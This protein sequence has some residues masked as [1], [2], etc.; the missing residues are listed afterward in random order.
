MKNRAKRI[1][2]LCLTAILAL[3]P[4]D[5]SFAA[6]AAAE[7]NPFEE[8]AFHIEGETHLE[9]LETAFPEPL[10]PLEPEPPVED[11]SPT[12]TPSPVLEESAAPVENPVETGD[13]S[14]EW[15]ALTPEVPAEPLS[16]VEK[17]TYPDA[18]IPEPVE[19]ATLLASVDASYVIQDGP[20]TL[21]TSGTYMVLSGEGSEGATT[22]T[23]S[24]TGPGEYTLIL[25]NVEINCSDLRGEAAVSLGGGANVT[26]TLA[27]TNT[28][29]SGENRA[30]IEV[31]ED[32]SL[33]INGNGSLTVSG[34]AGQYNASAGI[35]G[36]AEHTNGAISIQSGTITATGGARSYNG[37]AGIGGGCKGDGQRITISGGTVTANGSPESYYGAAGIGGGAWGGGMDISITGGTVTATGSHDSFLG[38]AG[39]GGGY[40]GS[41]QR[42]SMSGGTV[43]AKSSYGASGNGAGIGGGYG[44]TAS[45][46]EISGNAK[47]TANANFVNGKFDGSN[48]AGI[49]GGGAIAEDGEKQGGDADHITISGGTVN[50][51]GNSRGAGIGGGCNGNA[52]DIQITGGQINAYGGHTPAS[53]SYIGG[54]GI[55]GGAYGSAER[56]TI[57]TGVTDT[58][59]LS[60]YNGYGSA[61]IGGGCHGYAKDITI[62]NSNLYATGNRGSYTYGAGIGG[63]LYGAGLNILIEG[64]TVEAS[65]AAGAAIGSG[66][67]LGWNYRSHSP[68]NFDPA[69]FYT[70]R[71]AKTHGTFP[72]DLKFAATV[73]IGAGS[74]ITTSSGS[75]AAIGSGCSNVGVGY[76]AE[77]ITERYG[78]DVYVHDCEI[79]QAGTSSSGAG[80]G[81]G[82]DAWYCDSS[83][84]VEN[85]PS[86]TAQA[87]GSWQSGAS[88]GSG[89][90]NYWSNMELSVTDCGTLTL[91]GYYMHGGAGI[92]TGTSN[93]GGTANVTVDHC[94]SIHADVGYFG[95]GLGTGASNGSSSTSYGQDWRDTTEF[96]LTVT[97]CGPIEITNSYSSS[98]NART[99]IGSG[100]SNQYNHVEVSV[101]DC[102]SI[103]V[104]THS[105][106]MVGIG[107]GCGNWN[108]TVH[109]SLLRDGN[110]SL[111]RVGNSN[112]EGTGI[113]VG[114]GSG[115]SSERYPNDFVVSLKDCDSVAVSM[116]GQYAT[117]I[118][119]GYN[120]QSCHANITLD[121]C[122]PVTVIHSGQDSVGIGSGISCTWYNSNLWARS[123]ETAIQLKKCR[124]ISVAMAGINNTG[125]GC[126]SYSS[127]L[128]SHIALTDCGNVTVYMGQSPLNSSNSSTYRSTGIGMGRNV[129]NCDAN[130]Q[131]ARCGDV[132]VQYYD[133]NMGNAYETT[134]I[135]SGETCYSNS[136]QYTTAD[137]EQTCYPNTLHIQL[138]N[139]GAV[140]A[141]CGREGV[142]IGAGYSNRDTTVTVDITDCASVEA[143]GGYYA[144]GI[145]CG[146]SCYSN[147]SYIEG[148]RSSVNILRCPGGV[149]AQGGRYGAAIGSGGHLYHSGA[150]VEVRITD[151][152]SVVA[153]QKM[154]VD[155]STIQDVNASQRGHGAAIGG[156][157]YNT[158]GAKVSVH[159]TNCT[160]DAQSE[161][162]AAIGCGD[163]SNANTV[164]L[165]L[166]NC[167]VT[168][169]GGNGGGIGF[170]DTVTSG[171]VS[172]LLD[173][174]DTTATSL[175]YGAGIGGGFDNSRV[176]TNVTIDGGNVT[177]TGAGGGAG[178][179][180]GPKN[181]VCR[182]NVTIDGNAVVVATGS[183]ATDAHLAEEDDPTGS[184]AGA[185][186]GGTSGQYVGN[187][188]I[189]SGDVTAIG[190]GTDG[191]CAAGIGGGSNAKAG[192]IT[193]NGGTV[194]ATAGHCDQ[195][196][197][198]G[199]GGGANSNAGTVTIS[200]GNV[201]ATGRHGSKMGG[202]GIGGGPRGDGGTVVIEGGTVIAVGS[203]RGAGIGGGFN[204]NGGDVTISGGTVTVTGGLYD[205]AGIGGGA[206]GEGGTLTLSGDPT[207]RVYG[208]SSNLAIT[209]E[210]TTSI[211]VFQGTM[212]EVS[213]EEA[214][215]ALLTQ[216]EDGTKTG[217]TANLPAGYDAF[218]LNLP[219]EGMYHAY[220]QSDKQYLLATAQDAVEDFSLTASGPVSGEQLTVIRFFDVTFDTGEG[221]DV[222]A[223][224]VR[225]HKLVTLPE[226]PTRDGYLFAGWFVDE[227]YTSPYDFS[228]PVASDI[229]LYAKWLEITGQPYAVYH[230]KANLEGGWDIGA[231]E[232]GGEIP[233][234]LVTAKAMDY[235]GFYEDKTSPD[236]VAS[237]YTAEGTTLTLKLYYQ[238]TQVVVEVENAG[239]DYPAQLTAPYGTLMVL[240]KPAKEGY[241][242]DKWTDE[243]GSTIDASMP[244]KVENLGGVIYA[245]WVLQEGRAAYQVKHYLR[246]LE[247]AYVLR[248]AED[249]SGAVGDSVTVT[250]NTYSGFHVNHSISDETATGIIQADNSL[251][252]RVYYDRDLITVRLLETHNTA[253][254]ITVEYGAAAN[255][256]T[257]SWPG[258]TFHGWQRED[259][260]LY[261]D[262]DK[263][264]SLGEA[265]TAQWSAGATTPYTVRYYQ[266]DI[267][268]EDME[269]VSLEDLQGAAGSTVKASI[270]DYPGFT[271]NAKQSNI[272]G[273]VDA[274]H[275]LILNVYYTRNTYTVTFVSNGGSP[276]AAQ[277]GVYYTALADA[278]KPPSKTGYDFEGWYTDKGLGD[279]HSFAVPVTH[280][281]TLYAKW[282]PRED[283]RYI[284]RH[285]QQD[286]SGDDY[287]L[288]DTDTL[289]GITDAT[290]VA[291]VKSYSGF[292][293]AADHEGTL[294]S[295]EIAPDGST[296]LTLYYDRDLHTVTYNTLGGTS[297]PKA[298]GIRYG[299]A[300]PSPN[301]PVK[302][303]YTFQHWQKDN[304]GGERYDF[305]APVVADLALY[306]LWQPNTY[307]VSFDYRGATGN[308]STK[309][310]AV[311]YDAPYGELP[312]PTRHGY[313]FLGWFTQAQ[314]GSE[315]TA[316]TVVKITASQTL[317]A[318]WS[319]REDTPY[320]V[321][322]YQQNVS[323][324]GYTLADTDALT[325]VTDTLVTAQAK[326][327]HGFREDTSY[328]G[329]LSSGNLAGDG[330]LVLKLYY[331]R[332]RRTLTIDRANGQG[333]ETESVY[334]GA[335]R[336]MPQDPVR[337]G[338]TFAGWVVDGVEVQDGQFTMPDNHVALTATWEAIDY[339][340]TYRYVGTVPPG[341]PEVPQ[342]GS[343]YNIGEELAVE[344]VPT[345]DGY[346]LFG[347]TTQDVTVGGGK[348]RMPDGN[349]TFTGEW[350]KA[351]YNVIYVYQGNIPENAPT[352]P[353]D[354][355]AYQVGA[356]VAVQP[357][358]ELE[359]YTFS[360][361]RCDGVEVENGIFEMPIGNVVFRGSWT[362][363][364][365]RVEF[366]YTGDVPN[367]V[368][369]LPETEERTMDDVVTVPAVAAVEGY[370]FCGWTVDGKAIEDGAFPMPAKDMTVTG[371][372]EKLPYH[373]SY[374]YKGQVPKNAPA[375]PVD[376]AIYTVGDPVQPMSPPALRGYTFSGWGDPFSMP[377]HDVTLTGSWS[378]VNYCISY[379]LNG[380]S[381][382]QEAA[383]VYTI[384]TPTFPFPT[385][386]RSGYVFGGWYTDAA[387]A[388]ESK[389]DGIT[390]GSVGDITVY[391]KW[392]ASP[393]N[394]SGGGSSG[395]GPSGGTGR[396][397]TP[398][399]PPKPADPLNK[400]DHTAYIQGFPDGTARPQA[401]IS[402][403][404]VATIFFRLLTQEAR[405]ENATTTHSFSDVEPDAWYA[406]PV[407]TLAAMGIVKGRGDGLFDPAATITRAEFAA[408]AARFDS[409]SYDGPDLFPDISGHW[410]GSE[411]NRAGARGWVKGDNTGLF[412]PDDPITR[413][414]A[415][416][417]I[418][419]VLERRPKT[420]GLLKDM[421]TFPDN[422]DP[423]AWYYLDIQEAANAHTYTVGK[424]GKEVWDSLK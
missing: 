91:G 16:P 184:D 104:K 355:H 310:K 15:A 196:G 12:P 253:E 188:I 25:S 234:Q 3:P 256:P 387:F 371:R 290:A 197:A 400:S 246:S 342:G 45:Y 142:A 177:A 413:A 301:S 210:I 317:Y 57:E 227:G 275:P 418:N 221:S 261:K 116:S 110:I 419:R 198:A 74:V 369:P 274:E 391:A 20:V 340:V 417:L 176:I 138:Q 273:V 38:A 263:I 40:M 86:I 382:S 192:T 53:E 351:N 318:H 135:G 238:R 98:S 2:S 163:R 109:V 350:R 123:P 416:T 136:N 100:S 322:H 18:L 376:A 62:R 41:A 213:E 102:E 160:V 410:A 66:Y 291:Q 271:F 332:N 95:T 289:A 325:G 129:Y 82:G 309:T 47:V 389:L 235:E 394:P 121:N 37:A 171:T 356:Q 72:D 152:G 384:E 236:R 134:G 154:L 31:P 187:I 326:E 297:V 24:V 282:T 151:C 137:G 55:G 145:G 173:H 329:R 366:R 1:V 13:F 397:S 193:I 200:G 85:C 180:T 424:D 7:V 396:P 272:S 167:T 225:T 96:Y 373:V 299:A 143:D 245:N 218:S 402:R 168:A 395:G 203:E 414:E 307:T 39:I 205:S 71:G 212:A 76:Y 174:C 215:I 262:G 89:S 64:S 405:E 380:G 348:F 51:Y 130:V 333:V 365:Y 401:N 295:A 407:A 312:S 343:H 191:C 88:I 146:Q 208:K 140:S 169:Q 281:L 357:A 316:E 36:G 194:R 250:P 77:N 14:E 206:N 189:N 411:I 185:G 353:V 92:G 313:D 257:P 319:P 201:T 81:T 80:I 237:G 183:G 182:A 254:S 115:T 300:I 306:A 403:A 385:P 147:Y 117:G 42:L 279:K 108:N 335:V 114:Y 217:Q 181:S 19:V 422:A 269:I 324:D 222:P 149:T 49:G 339:S 33:T 8:A 106:Y 150:E 330:S 190:G 266:Q 158:D 255:L 170:G 30:G 214:M 349:V 44:G 352:P 59:T 186:I 323:G 159:I 242:F 87:T 97:N 286:V 50:A 6:S 52:T 5:V 258:Y 54:A 243:E 165:T 372:W 229:T 122:G 240:G 296:Q 48:G 298:S 226:R 124:D 399:E 241:D 209:S 276:V 368:Q 346:V 277:K 230:Y 336:A 32:C 21:T 172:L 219:S 35:G 381:H 43:D 105:Q 231:I 302:E 153:N 284:V 83:I 379:V 128:T 341:A 156:G 264:E 68:G 278:P 69:L 4:L 364:L 303:G 224:S 75:G 84:V 377:A 406:Q 232:Y 195:C 144:T 392:T 367:D 415:V 285:Y 164:E 265:V 259:G 383:T 260:T 338:Y 328:A 292:H 228:T 337:R 60:A 314:G 412:R 207:L 211:P 398:S 34:G 308:N 363:N 321:E 370:R 293:Q 29:A 107:V 249:L 204:G 423:A 359:H 155:D 361:W 251:A 294:A 393:P 11:P 94:E 220:L 118:G 90:G 131:V 344:P 223:Q 175:T 320:R 23:V 404:E 101:T 148:L 362:P 93:Y 239:E 267:N 166:E 327:Y 126:G 408:I 132:S 9:S 22:N 125:V 288:A 46:I 280:D 390:Q 178:I 179:G 347:W 331:A 374:A 360:G 386:T 334:F 17:E 270:R 139:C 388:P 79:R 378:V 420:E 421:R 305:A 252:L 202:A 127:Y 56:I 99:G 10:P 358:P 103:S 119:T 113:G 111:E 354:P 70:A 248:V 78:V 287:T 120:C 65:A 58:R 409:S 304:E 63:G 26:L 244:V 112:Y 283:T 28:L 61:G 162:S 141:N 67:S 27:G 345:M 268:G 375:V 73:E 311:V 315:V 247:G 157:W 216:M 133:G 161:H 233:G 199:I